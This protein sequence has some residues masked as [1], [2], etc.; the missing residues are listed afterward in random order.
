MP[1]TRTRAQVRPVCRVVVLRRQRPEL[2][3]AFRCPLV[4]F[5]PVLSVLVSFYLM[6]NLPAATWVR[7]VVWMAV[8]L[9]VY[10][11]YGRRH[12]G[13]VRAVSSPPAARPVR[14]VPLPG[15][16]RAG[17]RQLSAGAATTRPCT[18]TVTL[19]KDNMPA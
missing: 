4:P 8:G 9:V 19:R 3:R 10:F 13:C 1:V 14:P 17:V 15:A 7:F 5:V 2:H 12:S 11:L 16:Q 18:L 6:L